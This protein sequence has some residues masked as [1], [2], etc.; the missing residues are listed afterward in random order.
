MSDPKPGTIVFVYPYGADDPE[1]AYP[2]IVC[3]VRAG[4]SA[5]GH[6]PAS[7]T[8]LDLMVIGWHGS[9]IIDAPGIPFLAKWDEEAARPFALAQPHE[10]KAD[11]KKA[12]A[13]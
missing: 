10:A 9:P 11:A 4:E 5:H 3:H 2:G 6:Q 7:P 12:K 13:A 8:T 1:K